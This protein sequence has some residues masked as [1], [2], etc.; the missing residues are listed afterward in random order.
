M[1][2]TISNRLKLLFEIIT[3]TSKHNHPTQVKQLSI[4]QQGYSEGLKDGI[5]QCY[6]NK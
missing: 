1:Q 3:I 4:F 5:R 6:T 2:L